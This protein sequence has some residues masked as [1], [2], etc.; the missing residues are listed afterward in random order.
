MSRIGDFTNKRYIYKFYSKGYG[1]NRAK[2]MTAGQYIGITSNLKWDYEGS[3]VSYQYDKDSSA[4][5]VDIIKGGSEPDTLTGYIETD[6]GVELRGISALFSHSYFDDDS[7]FN[8]SGVMSY[9]IKLFDYTIEYVK[10]NN[11]LSV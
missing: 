7:G 6:I 4:M 11:E 9:H 3:F 8:N 2:F 1:S 5:S 10:S